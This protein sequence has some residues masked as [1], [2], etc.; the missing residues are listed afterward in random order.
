[1]NNFISSTSKNFFWRAL[2]TLFRQGVLYLFFLLAAYFLS[3]EEFGRYNYLTA[4]IFLLVTF[5]DFGIST[6]ASTFVSK[7]RANAMSDEHQ[8]LSSVGMLV[9]AISSFV[10]LFL[11]FFGGLIWPKEHSLLMLASPLLFLVPLVALYDG[12]F[13]G[14]QRF[15]AV[16]IITLLSS[17]VS[18]PIGFFLIRKGTVESAILALV[19]FYAVILVMMFT[20]Y[21]G[22]HWTPKRTV[23]VDVAK[24]SLIIGLANLGYFLFSRIDIILMGQFGFVKEIGYYE[25]VN[26]ILLILLVPFTIFS[27]VIAP[28]ISALATKKKWSTIK[29]RYLSYIWKS[30]TVSAIF[31]GGLFFFFSPLVRA[32]LPKYAVPEMNLI[33]STVIIVLFMQGTSVITAVGF[34]TPSG[35]AKINMYTLLFF[36]ILNI[37]LTW[38][39]LSLYGFMGAIYSTVIVKI[40]ADGAMFFFYWNALHKEISDG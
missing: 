31:A 15:Q 32:F 18:L 22:S 37:P 35:F 9:L 11:V 8:I 5:A 34:C 24:Y 17:L 16:S 40:L 38:W 4:I 21:S 10:L 6:S 2:Q 33:I 26:K 19:V 28:E 7:Y 12:L 27:Q 29:E 30:F 25:L 20:S 1:M 23:L 13:R 3:P 14:T 36:G 39:F